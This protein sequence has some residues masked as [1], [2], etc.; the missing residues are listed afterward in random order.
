MINFVKYCLDSGG[1]LKTLLVDPDRMINPSLMNPSILDHNGSIL[2]N[3]RN[4]NYVLYHAEKNLNEH[5]WGPLCYL[6]PESEVQLAT[7][8]IMCSLDSSLNIE[9]YSTVDTTKLDVPPLWEF[10]GLEDCRL[11]FWDN[12]L[13]LCGVR[14]DTTTNGQ[15]RMELSEIIEENGIYKEINRSRI[16]APGNND[17]YCEKNWMPILDTP[18]HFVKWSNPTEI[19]KYDPNNNSC[20]TVALKD[21]KNTET[22]DL[23]GSS[24]VLKVDNNYIALVHETHLYKS[25]AGKKNADYY[26]RF[27]VWD[28][29]FNLLKVSRIFNFMGAKIEF[30]CGMSLYNNSFLIPFGYQDNVCFIISVP[31]DAIMEFI[32]G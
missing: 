13:F 25:E 1:N 26:H 28:H 22:A 2:L 29:D 10:V 16:P 23:R 3:L 6:H 12:K 14:R 21:M 31:K 5:A 7:H 11:V 9:K 19:V 32:Y 17:S 27:I 20:E 24:Q 30:S 4:V 18:Y 8:N 15:G